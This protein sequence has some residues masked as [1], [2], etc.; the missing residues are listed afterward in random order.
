M[1]G[2]EYIHSKNLV[3]RDI[4][5]KNVMLKANGV[6]KLIDFG[7]ARHLS[8]QV[9]NSIEDL[10]MSV[11]GTI[12]WMSPEIIREEGHGPKTD[13][14]SSGC[15]VFEMVD[16]EKMDFEEFQYHVFF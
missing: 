11:K 10:L 4:K 12:H 3:H 5:G 14:W 1:E 15:P 9:S 2:I 13:I 16:F 7:C 8:Q 6:I